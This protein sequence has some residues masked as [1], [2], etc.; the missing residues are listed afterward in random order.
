MRNTDTRKKGID[1]ENKVSCYL[2]SVGYVVLERNYRYYRFSEIDIIALD[3]CVVV[4][5][6]VKGISHFWNDECISEKVGC[7]KISKIRYALISYCREQ[8]LEDRQM[9]VDVIAVKGKKITHYKNI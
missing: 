8:K 7:D 5:I 3:G 6:E 2:E 4:A 1:F 9:R